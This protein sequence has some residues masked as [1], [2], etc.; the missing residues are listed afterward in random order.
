MSARP[1][2]LFG[3][4]TLQESVRLLT[5]KVED[6]RAE[7]IGGDALCHVDCVRAWEFGQPPLEWQRGYA[8]SR[9]SISLAW[10][11]EWMT[12]MQRLMFGD[13]CN[14]VIALN[15]VSAAIDDLAQRLHGK[16]GMAGIAADAAQRELFR[17]GS[18]AL[19]VTV[20]VS[21]Y[22]LL[23]VLDYPCVRNLM[24]TPK[25]VKSSADLP[26]VNLKRALSAVPVVLRVEI[27]Q[28]DVDLPSLAQLGVGDVI[29]LG[30]EIDQPGRVLSPEG[31]TLFGGYLGRMGQTIAIETVRLGK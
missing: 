7:W 9:G 31:K 22:N 26:K 28:A 2:V 24:G 18:G 23:C 15:A 3:A 5:E 11:P 13:D 10:Q 17:R 6:W 30:A 14:G 29:R 21:G 19:L 27:G 16:Q 1:F 20:S 12:E 4:S 8:G 25:T